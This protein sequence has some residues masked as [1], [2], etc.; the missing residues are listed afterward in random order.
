MWTKTTC[1]WEN[2]RPYQACVCVCQKGSGK[3]GKQ[4]VRTAF[5]KQAGDFK[6]LFADEIFL[7]TSWNR[8]TSFI[9][10]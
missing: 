7:Y 6:S 4:I 5:T 1:G 8:K 10:L 9:S 3:S 2:Q